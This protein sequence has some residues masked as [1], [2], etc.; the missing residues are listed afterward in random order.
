[1]LSTSGTSLQPFIGFQVGIGKVNKMGAC[2]L[3]SKMLFYGAPRILSTVGINLVTYNINWLTTTG[4]DTNWV[5]GITELTKYCWQIL[6]AYYNTDSHFLMVSTSYWFDCTWLLK[7]QFRNCKINELYEFFKW[8]KPWLRCY[9]LLGV[10]QFLLP[11]KGK[12]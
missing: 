12:G 11:W 1:M 5:L 10:L 3:K 9:T 7:R 8:L 6:N 4:K 2:Y